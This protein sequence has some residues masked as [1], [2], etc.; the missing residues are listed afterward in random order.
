M[1]SKKPVD[2]PEIYPV[3]TVGT[4]HTDQGTLLLAYAEDVLWSHSGFSAVGLESM[5]SHEL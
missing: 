2:A 1:V 4:P 5:S 3:P